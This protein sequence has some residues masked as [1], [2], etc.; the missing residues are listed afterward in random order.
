MEFLLESP[1]LFVTSLGRLQNQLYDAGFLQKN[2]G[3]K[4]IHLSRL[5]MLWFDKII[6]LKISLWYW[7]GFEYVGLIKKLDLRYPSDNQSAWGCRACRVAIVEVA[8]LQRLMMPGHDC[9]WQCVMIVA[10][11]SSCN[12]LSLV[13]SDQVLIGRILP[14][15]VFPARVNLNFISTPIYVSTVTPSS[16]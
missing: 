1:S 15:W 13:S 14:G 12:L 11:S 10:N 8:E 6:G 2:I 9:S 7:A 4:I 16:S 3:E 5:P